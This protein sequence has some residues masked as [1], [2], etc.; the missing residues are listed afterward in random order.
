MS[1][2]LTPTSVEELVEAVR[3]S[4]RVL[5]IGAGTKPR[6]SAANAVK[7]SMTKLC[8]IIE[9]EPSEFTFTALAGTPVREIA[10]AL[11]ERGQYLPFDPMWLDAGATLGGMVS[12]VVKGGLTPT[13]RFLERCTA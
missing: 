9:Y 13:K 7:I 4:P 5:A 11:A 6:L 3:A 10:V 2:L 8:G 1:V 12:A